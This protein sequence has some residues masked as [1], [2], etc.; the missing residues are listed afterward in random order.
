MIYDYKALIEQDKVKESAKRDKSS[1][2]NKE[3]DNTKNTPPK[4]EDDD[5]SEEEFVKKQF[6]DLNQ[7]QN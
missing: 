6:T 2:K 7:I 5:I 3:M 4:D 1:K